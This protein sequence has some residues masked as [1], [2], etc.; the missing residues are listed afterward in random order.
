MKQRVF[1]IGPWSPALRTMVA[2][3]TGVCGCGLGIYEAWDGAV[4]T[5]I[6]TAAL[7]CV[8]QHRRGDVLPGSSAAPA[9]PEGAGNDARGIQA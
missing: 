8:A 1:S 4:V 2:S 5:V 9:A 7:D 6:D 3:S